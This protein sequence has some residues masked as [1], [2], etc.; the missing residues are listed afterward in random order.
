M[1]PDPWKVVLMADRLFQEKETIPLIL[2]SIRAA[3]VS[4]FHQEVYSL[5]IKGKPRFFSEINDLS[6]PKW[7]CSQEQKRNTRLAADFGIIRLKPTPLPI[8]ETI[9]SAGNVKDDRFHER[10]QVP[11]LH[12]FIG[13]LCEG[14]EHLAS[15]CS[16]SPFL[17][18]RP[19]L[20]VELCPRA[21]FTF[22]V[23]GTGVFFLNSGTK[24]LRPLR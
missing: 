3:L 4:K 23:S 8:Y 2:R 17:L 14:P 20:L 19:S 12:S 10:S 15:L 13:D 21:L 1:I 6:V 24:S 9:L 22:H 18:S 16:T 7:W 11:S 5:E